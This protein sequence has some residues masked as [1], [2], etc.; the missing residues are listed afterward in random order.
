MIRQQHP[1]G[2]HR[3]RFVNVLK[4]KFGPLMA[5]CIFE[6]TGANKGCYTISRLISKYGKWGQ[7]SEPFF[8]QLKGFNHD[9]DLY[10]ELLKFIGQEF[11]CDIPNAGKESYQMNISRFAEYL[12][13][14]EKRDN[15]INS[16]T[17]VNDPA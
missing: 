14:M 11:I 3:L 9:A 15:Y 1:M 4:G 16:T 5:Q 13:G 8:N 2:R 10:E 12:T 7:T 6:G 17:H